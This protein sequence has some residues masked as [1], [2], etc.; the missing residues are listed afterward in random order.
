MFI[1]CFVYSKGSMIGCYDCAYVK[2][3]GKGGLDIYIFD[4]DITIANHMLNVCLDDKYCR[5]QIPTVESIKITRYSSAG[6][7]HQICIGIVL[8]LLCFIL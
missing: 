4:Y 5:H 7:S 8:I 6:V 3:N 1:H 2:D